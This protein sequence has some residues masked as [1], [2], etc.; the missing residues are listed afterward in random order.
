MQVIFKLH[1]VYQQTLFLLDLNVLIPENHSTRLIDSVVDKLE[2]SDIISQYK[3]GGTSSYHLK[4]A[5]QNT[6]LWLLE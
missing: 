6:I 5:N 2:I 3:D 4:K 1:S